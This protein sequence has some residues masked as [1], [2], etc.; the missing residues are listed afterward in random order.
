MV[1]A[2]ARPADAKETAIVVSVLP[3]YSHH[4]RFLRW[5]PSG[6]WL[7][8]LGWCSCMCLH[9]VGNAFAIL[10]SFSAGK[11]P[12]ARAVYGALL[13]HC[14]YSGIWLLNCEEPGCG[15]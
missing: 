14:V 11:C 3:C 8:F 13:G 2:F 7:D 4:L 5:Q 12:L 6:R 1:P 15:L 9:T 10:P